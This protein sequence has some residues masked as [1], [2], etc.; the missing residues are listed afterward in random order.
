MFS[1]VETWIFDLDN[2]L[3]HPSA[4]LFDQINAR[5]TGF[6]MR[7]LGVTQADA[8]VL[9][10]T[11]WQR[12]GTTLRGLIDHHGIAP[13]RF[14]DEVHDIDLSALTPDAELAA[15][16]RRLPGTRIVHTNGA[17]S[18]AARVLAARGLEEVF[19]AVY[20]IEDK[21]LVPKPQPDA[22]HRIIRLSGL[23]PTRAAMVEDDARNLEVP[24]GL[25]MATVWLC[26]QAGAT[27]PAY[28]D[29]RI[30]RLTRFL[31]EFAQGQGVA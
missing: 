23:E 8:G 31:Q 15:A 17:R 16:I 21:A 2:T 28:V 9:R 26:H 12:H 3:Y 6:I 19:D 7:E 13:E 14:L 5:I 27:A 24:K 1:H 4:R 25:G 18:H 29:R 20:A 22:Y 10:R 30:T 11:Y